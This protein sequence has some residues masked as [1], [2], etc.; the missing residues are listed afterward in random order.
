[1]TIM[2]QRQSVKKEKKRSS[3]ILGR[4]ALFPLWLEARTVF[5]SEHA[6]L[7]GSKDTFA[8]RLAVV[9]FEL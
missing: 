1:M 7:A 4:K 3:C 6:M 2:I 8:V 5:T 9:A